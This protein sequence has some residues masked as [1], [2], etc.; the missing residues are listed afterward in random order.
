MK[1][2]E[3]SDIKKL[4]AETAEKSAVKKLTPE[5]I[6]GVPQQSLKK[7]LTQIDVQKLRNGSSQIRK[8]ACTSLQM[9][10]KYEVFLVVFLA[11]LQLGRL[12]ISQIEI[13]T[14][15]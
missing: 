8:S 7:K 9:R 4:I 3:Q 6:R 13:C 10:T 1:P 2:A 11:D 5:E 15:K 14:A 12:N